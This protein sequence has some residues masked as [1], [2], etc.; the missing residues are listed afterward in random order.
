M[1]SEASATDDRLAAAA[2][3]LL[4]G[5]G[6]RRL[7]RRWRTD[8]V[9]A[10]WTPAGVLDTLTRPGDADHDRLLGALVARTQTGDHDAAL[11]VLAALRPGLWALVHG[12]HRHD[13]AAYDELVTHTI[14]AVARADPAQDQLYDRLLGR[15]RSAA[16]RANQPSPEE[17]VAHI[18]EHPGPVDPVATRVMAR[19][20]LAHLRDI[21]DAGDIAPEV[22]AALVA[23]RV[24][25]QPVDELAPDR[26]AGNHLRANTSRL[27]RHLGRLIA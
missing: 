7:T 19:L 21:V 20:T 27:A 16:R 5:P 13:P 9:L 12:Y 6:A 25:G 3:A 24:H 26:R 18:P 4:S 23:N 2:K 22:W 14:F 17:P 15:V 8:P 11:L 10:G 1:A